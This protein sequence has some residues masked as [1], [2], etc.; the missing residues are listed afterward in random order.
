V[1][2][3]EIDCLQLQIER[4]S[5]QDDETMLDVSLGEFDLHSLFDGVMFEHEIP[6][7]IQGKVRAQWERLF[8]GKQ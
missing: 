7:M 8:M 2:D 3:L 6:E 1:F 5:A 4:A